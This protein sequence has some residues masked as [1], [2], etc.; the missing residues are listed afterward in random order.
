MHKTAEERYLLTEIL[1]AE[2]VVLICIHT[3]LLQTLKLKLGNH[4]SL[5]LRCYSE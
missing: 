5:S 1:K 4:V 3:C 2:L